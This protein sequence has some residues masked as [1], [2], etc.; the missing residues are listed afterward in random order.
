M[1]LG[2]SGV[3][4]VIPRLFC[5]EVE[6]GIKFCVATFDAVEIVPAARP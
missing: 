1:S 3:L 4:A 2:S 6:K 5:R